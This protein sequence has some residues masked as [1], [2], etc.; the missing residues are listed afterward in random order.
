VNVETLGPSGLDTIGGW[1]FHQFRVADFVLP[2]SQVKIRFIAEDA[3]TGS[4]VEAAVDDFAV[5]DPG[6]GGIQ[7]ICFG[8]GSGA[9]CPCFNFGGAGRGCENSATTGGAILT[10]T[11]T[12][13]LSSDTLV[14]TSS[15][16]RPTAFSLFLQGDLEVSPLVFGDGLRCTG[17][18]L[19]RL[20]SKNAVS[21]AVTAPTGADPSITTRSAAL[22]DTIPAFG[23]RLYQVYY[24]DPTA[25]FCASPTGGTFNISNA[26]RVVWGP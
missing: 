14:L 21:G 25:S 9:D 19:K 10:A 2:T 8:D 20:Y 18:S 1:I 15:G 3:G 26:L 17:G 5:V 24:R 12:P 23:T 6:C 7:S 16:E 13:S 4:I 11:G 22:G